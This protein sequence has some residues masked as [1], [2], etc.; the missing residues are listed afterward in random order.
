VPELAR[1]PDRLIHAPWSM[2]RADEVACG[3]RIG[4]DYP[5]PVIDHPAARER[6]LARF[7]VTRN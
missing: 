4:V 6:T 1:L 2:G 5:A 7:A 3:V